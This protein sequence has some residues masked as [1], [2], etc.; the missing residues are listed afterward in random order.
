MAKTA[1]QDRKAC[2][3]A[4]F[5]PR[6]PI[7]LDFRPR[8]P[9][10]FFL[11]YI[12]FLL[13]DSTCTII[14]IQILHNTHNLLS[15]C[16]KLPKLPS[17][18]ILVCEKQKIVSAWEQTTYKY[19]MFLILINIKYYRYSGWFQTISLRSSHLQSSA[20]LRHP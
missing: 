4:P 15:S 13:T 1:S 5:G 3:N 12:A 10:S 7:C 8:K 18:A 20:L 19:K 6:K 14:I 9:Q 11:T 17:V 2:R 16:Y